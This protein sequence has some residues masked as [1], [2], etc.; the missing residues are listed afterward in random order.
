M[1]IAASF[2]YL[3]DDKYNILDLI[4]STVLYIIRTDGGTLKISCT[5]DCILLYRRINC[6]VQ[7]IAI[8]CTSIHK[9]FSNNKKQPAGCYK[10]E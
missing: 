9:L 1:R 2:I 5:K 10:T 7:K 6:F 8:F 3:N 4:Y